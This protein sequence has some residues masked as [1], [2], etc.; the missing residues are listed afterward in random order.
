MDEPAPRIVLVVEDDELI[1]RV[2]AGAIAAAGFVVL[3]AANALD[4][5]TILARRDDIA[6]VFTD[7]D[8][9]GPLNGAELAQMLVRQAPWVSV[10]VTSGVHPPGRVGYAFIGKPYRIEAMID[11]VRRAADAAR[12]AAPPAPKP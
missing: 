12:P 8:M 9:P 5:M 6:V 10:V 7:V 2:S 4:A 1:R 11:L 3:Q